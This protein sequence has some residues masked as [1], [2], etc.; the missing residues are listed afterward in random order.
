MPLAYIYLL[1]PAE[2]NWLN[3]TITVAI[4]GPIREGDVSVSLMSTYYIYGIYSYQLQLLAY[5]TYP[6]ATIRVSRDR[7]ITSF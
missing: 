7:S 3:Q 2:L 4:L 6:I 1:E 5:Y